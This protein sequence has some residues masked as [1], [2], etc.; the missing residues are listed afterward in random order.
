MSDIR[1]VPMSAEVAEEIDRYIELLMRTHKN[2]RAT[3]MMTHRMGYTFARPQTAERAENV[4]D[5]H[6]F[7]KKVS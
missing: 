4:V 1:M 3:L 2:E 7:S 5:L 6:D